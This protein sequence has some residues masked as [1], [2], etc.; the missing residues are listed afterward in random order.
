MAAQL[1]CANR[2]HVL[3]FRDLHVCLSLYIHAEK[4]SVSVPFTVSV[5]AGFAGCFA[6]YKNL[7]PWQHPQG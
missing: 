2:N 6:G 1:A 5:G 7:A 3:A 4:V